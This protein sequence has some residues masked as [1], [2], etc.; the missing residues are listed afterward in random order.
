MTD[1]TIYQILSSIQRDLVCK[2][3]QFNSF[4]NY[5]Y[6]NCEDIMESVKPLLGETILILTDEVVNIGGDNYIKATAKII[7]NEKEVVAC[8][9][10]RETKTRAKFDASQLT[11]SASSYA[12][13]YA[14]NGLFLIDDNKDAD[15]NESKKEQVEKEKVAKAE[16]L[17]LKAWSENYFLL[18][19]NK[20]ASIDS[21]EELQKFWIKEKNGLNKLSKCLPDKLNDLNSIKN[22][23]KIRLK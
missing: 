12:R 10:A 7:L 15:S 17:K 20:L 16:D 8:G 18:M 2:K 23:L 1:K 19:S 6:R 9:F 22:Q 13:K 14:L 21:L 11:G 3:N 5:S 4:G